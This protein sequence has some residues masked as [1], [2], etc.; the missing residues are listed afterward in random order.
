MCRQ[1]KHLL[2][3]G[4]ENTYYVQAVKAPTVCGQ[5]RGIFNKCTEPKALVS[6]LQVGKW[7][8]AESRQ[9]Y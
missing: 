3:A 8:L 6:L 9:N 2:C 4:S 7:L 5:R 1:Q